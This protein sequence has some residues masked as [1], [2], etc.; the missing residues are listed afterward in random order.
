MP[1]PSVGASEDVKREAMERFFFICAAAGDGRV[2]PEEVDGRSS[3]GGGLRL[4][5]KRRDAGIFGALGKRGDDSLWALALSLSLLPAS[6]MPMLL[7]ACMALVDDARLRRAGFWGGASM[8]GASVNS[9]E[10]GR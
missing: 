7:R 8:Y 5:L 4:L 1:D 10:N 3:S 9:V 6:A 2:M